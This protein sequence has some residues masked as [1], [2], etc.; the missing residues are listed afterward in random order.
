M[1]TQPHSKSS[2]FLIEMLFSLLFFSMIAALCI[3]VFVQ[4]H[5]LSQKSENLNEAQNLASSLAEVIIASEGNS[6]SMRTYFPEAVFSEDQIF[7]YYDSDW[8]LTSEKNSSYALVA[9]LQQKDFTLSGTISVSE[10]K[11]NPKEKESEIYSLSFRH[12]IPKTVTEESSARGKRSKHSGQEN[13][14]EGTIQ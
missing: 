3:Q 11:K 5:R 4:S 1:R 6:S 14:K 7:L 9:S 8:N 13:T 12:H 10:N 2:L